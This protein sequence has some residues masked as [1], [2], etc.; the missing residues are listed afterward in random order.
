MLCPEDNAC[1]VFFIKF[2]FSVKFVLKYKSNESE[3][4]YFPY[5]CS[6]IVLKKAANIS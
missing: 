2:S 4:L 5:F 1:A 6:M 3:D